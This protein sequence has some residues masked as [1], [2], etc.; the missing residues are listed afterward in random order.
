MWSIGLAIGKGQGASM[1][2]TTVTPVVFRVWRSDG[3]TL[4]LFPTLLEHDG[5]CGSYAH[6]GQHG[7]ADYSQCIR[8][9]RPAKPSEYASLKLELESAPYEYKLCVYARRWNR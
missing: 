1:K 4:A 3:S 7:A 6:F 5:M 8:Q 9:T 2:D